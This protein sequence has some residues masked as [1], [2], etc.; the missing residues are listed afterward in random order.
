MHLEEWPKCFSSRFEL[1]QPNSR[2]TGARGGHLLPG[3]TASPSPPAVGTLQPSPIHLLLHP[4]PSFPRA[5]ALRMGREG[6]P[7]SY[8]PL[9]IDTR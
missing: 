5:R 2:R 4:T 6:L 9:L 3:L 1:L 7:V 8:F